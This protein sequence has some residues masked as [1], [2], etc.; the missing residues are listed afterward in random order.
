MGRKKKEETILEEVEPKKETKKKKTEDKT[1]VDK[2]IAS[3][4]ENENY[5]YKEVVNFLDENKLEPLILKHDAKEI[6]KIQR[7]N[8][9]DVVKL[10][11][12]VGGDEIDKNY[13]TTI[14]SYPIIPLF[15][16]FNK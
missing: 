15:V 6:S 9:G 14:L 1:Q 13:F 4:K 11:Y 2:F 10:I 3:L 5:T 7:F 8:V 16:I 12:Q